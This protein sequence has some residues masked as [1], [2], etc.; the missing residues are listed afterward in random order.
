MISSSHCDPCGI[1]VTSHKKTLV[2]ELTLLEILS[3]SLAKLHRR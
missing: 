1:V 3:L 2:M